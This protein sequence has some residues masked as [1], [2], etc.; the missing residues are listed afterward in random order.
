MDIDEQRQLAELRE[1]VDQLERRTDY[2]DGVAKYAFIREAAMR[3][4][5]SHAGW[6]PASYWKLAKELWDA[7]PED[8]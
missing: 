5:A 6:Q 7:K 8:C 2:Y 1:R 3:M 4:A